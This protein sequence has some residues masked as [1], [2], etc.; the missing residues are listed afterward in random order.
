MVNKEKIEECCD[1][2][3]FDLDDKEGNISDDEVNVAID[4]AV[5]EAGVDREAFLKVFQD[6]Y[7]CNPFVYTE[8]ARDDARDAKLH[9]RIEAP[10]LEP[11]DDID[12]FD[13]HI[14]G[15][16]PLSEEDLW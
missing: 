1:A 10:I 9:N 3:A 5:I 11:I 14:E 7:A 4:V 13:P 15:L 2:L 8:N 16:V 6:L 12:E